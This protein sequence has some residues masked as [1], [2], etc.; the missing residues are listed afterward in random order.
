[1]GP[2]LISRPKT[3]RADGIILGLVSSIYTFKYVSNQGQESVNADNSPEG[4]AVRDGMK[5]GKTQTTVSLSGP[6]SPT[7]IT[8]AD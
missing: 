1:M 4:L 6:S 8:R 2:P 7:R 3:C 5:F